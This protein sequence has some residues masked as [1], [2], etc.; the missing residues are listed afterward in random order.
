VYQQSSLQ[1]GQ[2][3]III[4][5]G[6][7]VLTGFVALAIDGGMTYADR[8][9]AQ[10]ASDSSSLA[11]A[12]IAALHM[13][14]EHVFYHG[15]NCGLAAVIEAE[16][17]AVTAAINQ[18]IVNTYVVD[19]DPGDGSGVETTCGIYDNGSYID[20]YVDITTY[21]SDTVDTGFLHLVYGGEMY[22][23][24]HSTVRVRPR[25]PLALGYA[26]VGLNDDDCL[27][28]Q[29]G[30]MF[31]GS[32]EVR[33]DGG[34]VFSN[35]CL[36]G[37]GSS[38]IVDVDESPVRYLTELECDPSG[39]PGFT[40][41]PELA[42]GGPLPEDAYTVPP[43][44]CTG[45]PNKG[46]VTKGGIISPGVYSEIDLHASGDTLIMEP[47][48][49]CI[50]GSPKA[51]VISGG[52]VQGYGVTIFA[53]EGE[54]L[55]SGN[56]QI[57]LSAPSEAPDPTP[58]I[59]GILI[60]LAKGND[61]AVELEGNSD[62]WLTGT[63]YAPDGFIEAKGVSGTHPTMH[64]QLIGHD[65]EIGGNADINIVFDG[66]RAYTKPTSIDMWR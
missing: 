62:T 24:V 38:L 64:T 54:V 58:A 8:R 36:R 42:S 45:L 18:A 21:I 22:N 31:S 35:G 53:T 60:Y 6:F 28:H 14:N 19:G 40:P 4:A 15:F 3:L 11:G 46:K 29:N 49:Y 65:V 27:G 55:L 43:P 12:G 9:H 44:D 61:G 50:T 1:R 56:A 5:F 13:E 30:V 66:S 52:T 41:V 17:L 34:G 23:H 2:A 37:N 7:L 10:A 16:E 57:Q 26:I 39:C 48:L 51:M 33:V 25:T 63:V 20:K 47:G 59:P 32:I